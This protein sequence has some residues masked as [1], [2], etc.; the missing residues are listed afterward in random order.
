MLENYNKNNK[1]KYT[2][3]FSIIFFIFALFQII[4]KSLAE[5]PRDRPILISNECKM[6][7]CSKEQFNSAYCKIDNSI[8]KTQWLN[9]IIQIGPLNYRYINFASYSNGDM[10]VETT[11]FPS[12]PKRYFYGL[13]MMEGHFLLT[14]ILMRKLLVM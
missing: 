4:N 11:S 7:Y 2:S 13:K 6:E 14:K 8:I 1:T 5:C 9:N 3:K 10:V 12:D